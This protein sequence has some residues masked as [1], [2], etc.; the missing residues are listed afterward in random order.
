MYHPI[1]DQNMI[2]IIPVNTY[3]SALNSQKSLYMRKNILKH[4]KKSLLAFLFIIPFIFTANEAK[5]THVMG[6][7]ITYKCVD[8]L[9]FEV[10]VKYY[11]WCKG[12]SFS[13]PSSR[14]KVRCATG[15]SA[16]V[17]LT[18]DNIKEITPVC[19]TATGECVPSNTWGTGE[20]IEQHT[21][22]FTMD[23]TS[24][25]SNFYSLR[26]CCKIII[27]TGQCC[28]NSNINTGAAN[29]N[30]YTYAEIDLC[31]APCNSSPS[32]T[33]EPIAIL[34]CNQ[35]FFFN[36]GAADT[37]DF[38]SLSYEWANPLSAWSVNIGYSGTWYAY[39]HPFQAYYPGSLTPPYK[40]PNASPPIGITL[41]SETGDIILTP[42]RCDEV[43]VAVI[44]VNEWRKDSAGVYKKIGVT[45][46]DMQFITK[47]CPDNNPP[48]VNGPYNYSTCAG[49][50]I[51]FN[52]T[53]N[54]PVFVP[55]PP[56]TTPPPDSVKI[57]WNRGIP[58]ATFTVINPTARLQTGRFCWTPGASHASDLPYTFTVT[59]RDNACP[60]NAVS[61][62]SFRVTVKHRAEAERDVDTL[63][64]GEYA[65]ESIPITGFRGTPSYRWEILDSTSNILFN[66]KIARFRS[67]ATFLSYKQQDTIL[68]RRGGTYIIKHTINNTPNN[69][70]TIYYDTLVVPPL[71]EAN[72]SL[73]PDTFICA[74]TTLR[75]EPYVSNATAPVRYQWS[76]MGVTDDG[77]FQFNVTSNFGD[78]LTYFEIQVSDSQ[79]DTAVSIIITDGS[80]CTSE[81]TIQVFL[82]ENPK[83]VL[84]PDPRLCTYD[85]ILIIPNLD[86][87]YWIDPLAGDTLRQGD[88]LWKEWYLNNNP[89][90]FSTADSVTINIRGE[91]VLRVYDSLGCEDTDTLYLFVNDTV[92]ADLGPDQIHCFNDTVHLIAAGLDTMGNGKSGIYQWYNISTLPRTFMGNATTYDFPAQATTEYEVVLRVTEGGR[93]CI[94]NDSLL[95]TVNPLPVINISEVG[96]ICCDY[97]NVSLNFNIIN[98]TGGDWSCWQYPFL[99]GN[100]T[101][102]T[103]SACGLI[104]PP[105]KSVDAFVAY[106]FQ[107]PSTGCIN[108]DSIKITVDALPTLILQEKTFCQDAEEIKLKDAIVVSPATYLGTPSWKCLDCNGNDF[109]TMLDDR[110]LAGLTDYYLLIGESNYT[111]ENPD[112][113]TVV[114]EF[115]YVNEKGCRS[116]DTVSIQIWKVPKITFSQL[117]PLCWNDGEI[118]LNTH[119][120]VNLTDGVWS[121]YDSTGFSSCSDL[122]GLSGDTINTFNSAT[123]GG[124]YYL[125]YTHI[126]TGCP[127][128][129]DTVLRINPLPTI[130][131]DPF[132]RNPARYCEDMVNE[133]LNAN[134]SGGNWTSSNPPALVSGNTFSPGGATLQG[135]DIWFYYNFTSP[136][137]GCMNS[138]SISVIVEPLPKL[139]VPADDEYCRAD[140]VLTEIKNYA[141]TASDHGGLGYYSTDL[142]GNKSRYTLSGD[143]VSVNA[144]LTYI[145]DSSEIFRVIVNATGLGSCSDIT[146]YFDIVVNPIPEG[147]I[148]PSNPNGCNPVTSDFTVDITNKVDPNTATYTWTLGEGSSSTSP[149]PNATYTTDGTSNITL[150]L[151]SDK[152]CKAVLT[153]SIDVYPLPVADFV[154]NPNNYTTAALPRFY[155]TDQSTVPSVLGSSIT[156]YD[157]DFD[158]F[159]NRDEDQ[160]TEQNPSYFYSADTATYHVK[161]VVTTNH[162]CKDSIYYPVVVG[163]DLIVYIPNAFTPDFAGPSANEGFRATISGEKVMDL[164][165]FNRWGEIMFQ[166][167][168][169]NVKWDGTYKGLPAQQDVYAYQLKVTALNDEVYTY[170]GTITLIR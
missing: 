33:S 98:P 125:R 70:P 128:F 46:R 23:F 58:G 86:T 74:G 116:K 39:N 101:F 36:N 112:K 152:G 144:D 72:L 35:P 124:D 64:C 30:F 148:V 20:G 79:V 88:T 97:G 34:C 166:T 157:W 156:N 65:F 139:T 48:I 99:V 92:T 50:Q 11:R 8:T 73:G 109:N 13:N 17:S 154:P 55:P 85:S 56:A 22:T 24:S 63:P 108:S 53:T 52:I 107:E 14:T 57:S 104:N 158:D 162:G 150:T 6:A 132:S 81:D 5:A 41:D 169:K 75:L 123:V 151:E 43:T 89:L 130:T 84:P 1:N 105:Y 163:P 115:T 37:S 47:T 145:T 133:T 167:S 3:L 165:I 45:R 170:T 80:G 140:G 7:D 94:D 28:R 129:N 137:T 62:R 91:Y 161:L 44:Q 71:L 87:A 15:G 83:A 78:T 95:V 68:F 122:G 126:S 82:K 60:L 147:A 143:D 149:T 114:L 136:A 142:F 90:P 113:D 164:I 155:F 27:E 61:V 69:C 2:G 9:K 134:P 138:D 40:N 32:L 120:G 106:T 12:V 168:D 146:E 67:T 66:P 96:N 100:S 18:L 76:T 19:A 42:T 10:T 102:Y 135:S 110:G 51:C 21:Y 54:D 16:S 141:I 26:N 119:S 117:D 111:L 77:D 160:S 25:S 118:S 38:D 127:V 153:S 131:I 49:T 31:K 103:D 93:E 4:L 159:N 121:C 29:A 59:A